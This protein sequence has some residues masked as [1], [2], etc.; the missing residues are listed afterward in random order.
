MVRSRY[1]RLPTPRW[2]QMLALALA[3]LQPEDISMA[4]S[5]VMD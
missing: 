2:F 5:L 4:I 1:I 3:F